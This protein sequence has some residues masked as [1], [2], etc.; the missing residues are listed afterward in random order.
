MPTATFAQELSIDTAIARLCDERNDDR[1]TFLDALFK[2]IAW[3]RWPT[4]PG[5]H[6]AAMMVCAVS[7]LSAGRSA[8]TLD[9]LPPDD[10]ALAL[11]HVSIDTLKRI[12]SDDL[13]AMPSFELWELDDQPYTKLDYLAQITHFLL[14]YRPPSADPRD[15]ASLFKAYAAMNGGLFRYKWSVSRRTF[16]T[17]W[18]E[19]AASAPFHY[20]E[21]VHPSLEFSLDPS[22]NDF[23]ENI[24]E[25]YSRRGEL[26]RHLARCLAAIELL[27]SKLDRRSLEAIRF[28]RF[29]SSLSAEAIEPP[30]LP[31]ITD[32]I[33]AEFRKWRN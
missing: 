32:T 1:H 11:R 4:T 10:L 15:A 30:E 2:F 17:F 22:K 12:C 8:R 6:P 24:D 16:S 28:P 29:P 14:A 31:E 9:E 7:Y 33:R 19:S 3:L 13:F 25:A 20:V 27:Q 21:R 5:D 26:R 18:R 23:A